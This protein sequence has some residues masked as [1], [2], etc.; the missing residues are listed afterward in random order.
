MLQLF[1]IYNLCY[2]LCFSTL[3]YVLLHQHTPQCV[4]SVQYGCFRN[5]LICRFPGMLLKY[6]LNDFEMV[7]VAPIITGI[8]FVFIF[9][10]D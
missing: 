2:M 1:F 8:T 10:M 3:Q 9:H 5:S 6:C 4:C 7:P